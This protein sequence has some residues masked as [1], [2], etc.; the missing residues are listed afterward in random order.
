MRAPFAAFPFAGCT[1]PPLSA[2]APDVL[3]H[4]GSPTEG[5]ELQGISAEHWSLRAPI[6]PTQ[7]FQQGGEEVPVA[8]PELQTSAHLGG[9]EKKETQLDTETSAGCF[10]SSI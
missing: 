7:V 2:S 5:P 6:L 10:R 3:Q 9:V 8:S 4:T 1:N